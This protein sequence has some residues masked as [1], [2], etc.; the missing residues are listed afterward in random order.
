MFSF[1][2]Q[3]R[4]EQKKNEIQAE[5]TQV[6]EKVKNDEKQKKGETDSGMAVS[7]KRRRHRENH[8]RSTYFSFRGGFETR[9]IRQIQSIESF[10]K[11]K[12]DSKEF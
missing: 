10:R 7:R 5:I 8:L 4:T 11:K 6:G 3:V 9:Y 12:S 1:F 2:R